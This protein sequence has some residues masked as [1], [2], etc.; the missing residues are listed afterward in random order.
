[1]QS[2]PRSAP[3]PVRGGL[4]AV[5]QLVLV[6]RQHPATAKDYAPTDEH[7]VHAR[8]RLY[9]VVVPVFSIST[10]PMAAER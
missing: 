1:V 5:A 2:P 6:H 7:G 3:E 9:A 8:P 10:A 4:G